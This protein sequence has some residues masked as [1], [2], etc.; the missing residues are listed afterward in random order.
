MIVKPDGRQCGCGRR[1]CLETYVSATGIRRTVFELLSDRT[2]PSVLREFSYE[3]LSAEDISK[4]AQDGDEI[5]LLAF[6][7]TGE[8]LGMKLA[9]FV[10]Y[11][12]PEKI[13]LTGGLTHAGKFLLDPAK[14]YMEAYLLKV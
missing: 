12:N 7:R 9:D 13:I 8:I 6:D 1:G 5:A 14:R 10:A 3:D 4:A 2:T 11:S